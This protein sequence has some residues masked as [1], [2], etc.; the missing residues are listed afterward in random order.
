[1]DDLLV[2]LSDRLEVRRGDPSARRQRLSRHYSCGCGNCVYFDETQCRECDATLGYLADEGRVVALT[3]GREQGT[4]TSSG[5]FDALKFCANKQSPAACNWM[6]SAEDPEQLCTSC[7]LTR[8]VP[9]LTD[10][11]NARYW[12][13]IEAAK[14]R[15]VSQL[16][17]LGPPLRSK[18][19]DDPQNGV[20]FDFLRS[21]PG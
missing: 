14:R 5:R 21:P 20:M 9:D 15:L 12:N 11:D 2:L 13:R 1:M 6:V 8:A 10:P 17:A 4:W 19:R 16:L 7:R 18:H 3:E